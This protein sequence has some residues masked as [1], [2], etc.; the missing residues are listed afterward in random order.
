MDKAGFEKHRIVF[1]LVPDFSLIAFATA[2]EPLRMANRFLPRPA[3]EWTIASAS[4]APVASSSGIEIAAGVSVKELMHGPAPEMALVCGGL[5]VERFHDRETFNWLRRMAASGVITGSLCTGAWVLAEAGL[6]D[7]RACAIHWEN[8]PAFA[9]RF[10]EARAHADLF[11]ADGNLHTCAGGTAALDMMV[12][13]ISRHYGR[14]LRDKVCE[15]ALIDHARAPQ[16]RQRMPLCSRLG[17]HNPKLL[18]IIE[19]MEANIAEP[20]DL[21]DI[22]RYAG[23]SRRQ[24]ER[25]FS[26]HVGLPPARYYLNLRLEHAQRLLRQTSMPV[27]EVAIA[28]GFTSASHFSKCYRR[29]Y[30]RPP[31]AERSARAET[32]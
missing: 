23:L 5:N 25:L 6:L 3:F 27:I 21:P 7:G 17:S 29:L 2:I 31:H 32:A 1:F 8:L 28:C 4:G 15:Q 30:N 26:K 11:I 18:F 14:E 24:V 10:P 9:E 12:R 22:A 13:F 19:L 20:L 16:E